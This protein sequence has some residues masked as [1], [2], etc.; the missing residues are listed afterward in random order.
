M[1]KLHSLWSHLS[2]LYCAYVSAQLP[3]KCSGILAIYLHSSWNRLLQNVGGR[4]CAAKESL[5]TSFSD[6]SKSSGKARRS[7]CRTHSWGGS[8]YAC[9]R[10]QTFCSTCLHC[11]FTTHTL[12]ARLT[13]VFWPLPPKRELKS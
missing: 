4:N 13:L 3:S 5:R 12:I 8:K 6:Q 1:K 7:T 11:Y 2:L 10:N 9:R